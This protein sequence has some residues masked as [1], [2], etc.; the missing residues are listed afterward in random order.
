MNVLPPATVTA[1]ALANLMMAGVFV[2][3]HVRERRP[4]LS[5]FALAWTLDAM[6]HFLSLGGA[7][8]VVF[9]SAGVTFAAAVLTL[10]E[11]A[12]RF[13][14][15]RPSWT[16]RALTIGLILWQGLVYYGEPSFIV[17]H[18]PVSLFLAAVRLAVA[19]M[20]WAAGG[21]WLGRG[22]ATCAMGLWA[23][24][25]L[26]YP[27]LANVPSAAPWGFAVSAFLG[28]VTAMGVV[29]AYFEQARAEADASEMRL[30]SVFDGAS[31]G[32]AT[33]DER[34]RVLTANLALAR[35]L[36]YER[37]DE[38]EGVELGAL[39]GR[40]HTFA[41]AT[42]RGVETWRRPDGETRLVSVSLSKARTGEHLDRI[43][44]FV[45]DVTL[46]VR[47]E[48]QEEERRRLEALGRL[49]GGVAHDFNNLLQVISGATELAMRPG[50]PAQQRENLEIAS[51][52]AARG[53]ELT[54]QL[55]TV[56]RRQAVVPRPTDLGSVVR[57]F[58]EWVGR[59]LGDRV[60]LELDVKG[61]AHVVLADRGQL[62]QILVNLVT[63]ARDAMPDGGRVRVAL[64]REPDG[65]VCLEVEDEGMGMDEATRA[66]IFEPFF[67]T[68][69]HGRG[70]GLGLA[71]VHGIAAQHGWAL[72]VE[73]APERGARFAIR[74]PSASDE[75]DA[76]VV[77]APV[78]SRPVGPRAGRVLVVDDDV[79]VRKLLSQLL[80]QAGYEVSALAPGLHALDDARAPECS[81]LVTDIEMP[82]INGPE[83]VRRVRE[84]CP[85]LGVVLM[86][87]RRAEAASTIDARTAFLAK[88]FRA[89]EL[90]E[91]IE[92]VRGA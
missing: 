80:G 47:A 90:I 70:T 17:Q 84:Q 40:E 51:E 66:R 58:S 76:D 3:L 33:L 85:E 9:F 57:E 15:R 53:A 62:E 26:S 75:S 23:V 50:D 28:L 10:A 44:V 73:S 79:A 67:T 13:A 27:F 14:G 74:F 38:L 42:L 63:N 12:F 68:K 82:G 78:P 20:L 6:R 19:R 81:V 43:D 71:T 69:E 11:G 45:R 34:G 61:D 83:L 46:E 86:S 56:G 87:G 91:A 65:G 30:R 39:V 21:P 1:V 29:M 72:T 37:P 35:L 59:L 60:W 54:R 22:V 55:L 5:F 16:V 49:A 36:G 4:G 24:H 18:L 25:A 41:D 92:R 89:E 2:L 77:P 88:P 7:G 48:A 64:R 52:A 8:V 31:D 32:I